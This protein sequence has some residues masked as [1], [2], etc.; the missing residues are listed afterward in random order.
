MET[1]EKMVHTKTMV[2][3]LTKD[4]KTKNNNLILKITNKIN[5]KET[6][7]DIISMV[8]LIMK[9][10]EKTVITI[11]NKDTKLI[12]VTKITKKVVTEKWDLQTVKNK[13]MMEMLMI[14]T[15]DNGERSNVNNNQIFNCIIYE[16]LILFNPKI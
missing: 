9:L 4:S 7:E 16:F 6:E 13:I 2:I 12:K 1:V 5:S 14:I 11:T 15:T 3:W 8:T 10:K